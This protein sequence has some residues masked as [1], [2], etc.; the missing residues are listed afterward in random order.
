MPADAETCAIEGA[1]ETIDLDTLIIAIGQ[2]TDV[3]GLEA[4]AMTKWSTVI[5]DEAHS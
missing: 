2:Q 3:C 4:L 5:A 1:F